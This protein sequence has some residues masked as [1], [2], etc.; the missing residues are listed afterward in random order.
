MELA[1][2]LEVE[3]EVVLETMPVLMEVEVAHVM[4]SAAPVAQ[5]LDPI[6]PLLVEMVGPV[7]VEVE[8]SS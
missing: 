6:I 3:V 1:K 8:L 4:V 5:I 7:E 2:E